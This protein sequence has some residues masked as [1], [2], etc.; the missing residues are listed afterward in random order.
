MQLKDIIE[1]IR[2]DMPDYTDGAFNIAI[3]S[4]DGGTHI[5]IEIENHL[6]GSKILDA[7]T[8]RFSNTRIIVMK[9]PQGYCH[10]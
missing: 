6:D 3:E 2:L 8:R 4:D 10:E 9:V 1:L 5:T 7:F